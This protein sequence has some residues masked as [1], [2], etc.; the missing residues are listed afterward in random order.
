MKA[1]RSLL[2]TDYLVHFSH[3]PSA[4]FIQVLQ[5]QK[6]LKAITFKKGLSLIRPQYTINPVYKMLYC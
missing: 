2:Y 5:I 4:F 6:P 1:S 3:R